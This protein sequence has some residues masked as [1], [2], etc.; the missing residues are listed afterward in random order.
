MR[1]RKEK[2]PRPV[3]PELEKLRRKDAER[4]DSPSKYGP[5][6]PQE[7]KYIV[8]GQND[9]LELRVAARLLNSEAKEISGGRSKHT[10]VELT[11]GIKDGYYRIA[12][13]GRNLGHLGIAMTEV[14]STGETLTHW[15]VDP[16]LRQRGIGGQLLTV[17]G[18]PAI[19]RNGLEEK[20]MAPLELLPDLPQTA[21]DDMSANVA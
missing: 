21:S 12:L 19:Y 6:D 1:F 17:L 18:V 10:N 14:T 4:R 13:A 5:I 20:T 7:I 9:A 2:T 16:S 11:S 15:Y 3:N 8:P